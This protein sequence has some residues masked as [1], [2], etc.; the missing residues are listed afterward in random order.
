MRT[1]DYYLYKSLYSIA[2]CKELYEYCEKNKN[3]DLIDIH[4]SI[5]KVSTFIIESSKCEEKLESF[6]TNVYRTNKLYFGY[7]LF[8]EKPMG[9][10]VNVYE[11]EN[12]EYPYHLDGN[13]PGTM[14]DIK[15]TAILNISTEPYKGGDFHIF[16]GDDRKIVEINEPGTLL[17]FASSL[18]HR[19]SPVTEG[20]RVTISTWFEGP[21]FR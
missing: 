14:S 6:F 15:L 18:Y 9:V 20:R 4:T 10:N 1:Y 11:K 12:N 3:D 2:E 7:D 16:F 13:E 8:K 21:N 17:I 5:K 19:V